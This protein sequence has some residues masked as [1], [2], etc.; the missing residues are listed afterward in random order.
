M[1]HQKLHQKGLQS[2]LLVVL[3]IVLTVARV[4][5]LGVAR[6]LEGRHI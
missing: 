2:N 6:G 5:V 3:G 1:W 4:V